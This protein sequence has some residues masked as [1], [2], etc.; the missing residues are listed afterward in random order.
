MTLRDK[1]TKAMLEH[2]PIP[3][4]KQHPSRPWYFND[5]ADNLLYPM[6]EKVEQAYLEGDGDELLPYWK[7][8]TLCPPKMGSIA[9]SSAMS[10]NLLANG[11]A[12]IMEGNALPAGTYELQYEKKMFT[13]TAGKHPANLDVFLTDES[14]RTAIFCEMKL[15]EWL[16]PPK[17]LKDSYRNRRFYFASDATAVDHPIDAFA[18]FQSVIDEVNRT[19]F[20]RYDAW[21]MLRHLLAIYNYTSYTTKKEVDTYSEYPSMA[22]KYSHIILANVVNEF[23]SERIH[24]KITRDEYLTALHQEQYEAKRFVDIIRYSEIPHLFNN[25]CN[26][27]IQVLYMSAQ[28]FADSLDMPQVKRDYLKRYFT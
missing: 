27:D 22:G 6:D 3:K 25:N 9:S 17:T 28:A 24:N 11:P 16:E 18:V 7:N 5:Y 10:F 23:S 8:G 14:G 12:I 26:A 21:Q 20:T 19:A 2:F 1:V 13:I 4:E 15:L